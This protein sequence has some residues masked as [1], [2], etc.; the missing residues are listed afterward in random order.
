M[1]RSPAQE[2]CPEL[3]LLS[4]LKKNTDADVLAATLFVRSCVGVCFPVG[5]LWNN[6]TCLLTR[7]MQIKVMK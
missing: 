4:P 5:F 6:S 7:N 3:L 2:S 1:N